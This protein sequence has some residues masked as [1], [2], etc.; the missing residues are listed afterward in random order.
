V[1]Q[2]TRA[3]FVHIYK[4]RLARRSQYLLELTLTLT[5][6]N[7]IMDDVRH[8][9]K[10]FGF[11]ICIHTCVTGGCANFSGSILWTRNGNPLRRHASSSVKH[12]DCNSICP[13]HSIIGLKQGKFVFSRAPTEEE[14]SMVTDDDDPSEDDPSEDDEMNIDSPPLASNPPTLNIE[15][16]IPV[17]IRQSK[18]A[19]PA[20]A[21]T[22]DLNADVVHE[23]HYGATLDIKTFNIIYVPDPTRASSLSRADNDLAFIKTEISDDEYKALKHLE[24]VIHLVNRRKTGL[25]ERRCIVQMQEWVSRNYVIHYKI[26]IIIEKLCVMVRFMRAV[27]PVTGSHLFKIDFIPW[28]DFFKAMVDASGNMK[29]WSMLLEADCLIGGIDKSISYL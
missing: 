6:L 22:V 17:N 14:L 4:E 2:V 7:P 13:G 29:I 11:A 8:H 23:T 20:V 5:L 3:S 27:D 28:K 21:S 12:P 18:S 10:T 26:L 1:D 15:I 24:G 25:L 16:P 19:S 9:R